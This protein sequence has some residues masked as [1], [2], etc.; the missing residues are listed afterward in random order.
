MAGSL[1]YLLWSHTVSLDRLAVL[2]NI[3]LLTI[4][5]IVCLRYDLLHMFMLKIYVFLEV[6]SSLSG[7]YIMKMSIVYYLKI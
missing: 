6:N 3:F 2:L 1:R 7:Q 4:R 5:S